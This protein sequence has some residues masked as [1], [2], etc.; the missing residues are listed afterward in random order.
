MK[1]NLN[2]L[3]FIQ[4]K[5]NEEKEPDM[6]ETC[7]IVSGQNIVRLIVRNLSAQINNARRAS[8]LRA[9]NWGP[10]VKTSPAKN[11]LL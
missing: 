10:G 5:T 9:Q 2:L 3:M 7:D 8:L 4:D 11:W 6:D 1:R